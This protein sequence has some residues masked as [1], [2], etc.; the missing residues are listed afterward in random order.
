VKSPQALADAIDR[1]LA[2]PTSAKALGVAG[3]ERVTA[4]FS[5]AQMV[6]RYGQLYESLV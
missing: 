2:D 5:W 4:H 6:A 1:L 3:R